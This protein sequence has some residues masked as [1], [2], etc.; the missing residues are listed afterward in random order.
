MPLIEI[1]WNLTQR[2][3]HKVLF[4]VSVMTYRETFTMSGAPDVLKIKGEYVLKFLAARTHL[5]GT[6]LDFQ[7]EQY[8]YRK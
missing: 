8:I 7:M 2:K 6:N 4:W 5:G 1:D 3:V